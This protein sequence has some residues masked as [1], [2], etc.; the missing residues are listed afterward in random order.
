MRAMLDA[1]NIAGVS[2][3][4]FAGPSDV[5]TG[6]SQHSGADAAQM[7]TIEAVREVLGPG[8]EYRRQEVV[9]P[10]AGSE[11]IRAGVL[12]TVLSLAA[13][14][15]YVWFR[16]EW[17]FGVGAM[18]ATFHDVSTTVGLFA[19]LQVEFSLTILAA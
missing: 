12:A 11:L 14:A 15:V 2:L 18:V 3:Q 17:Q 10:S 19:L 1:L 9:G 5:V 8:V 13:I 7:Q 6:L 4:E 16:F